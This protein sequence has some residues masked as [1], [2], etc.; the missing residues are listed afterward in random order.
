MEFL[1]VQHH[2]YRLAKQQINLREWLDASYNELRQAEAKVLQI[3]RREM[4]PAGR[5][6]FT[7]DIQRLGAKLQTAAEFAD[8]HHPFDPDA[9]WYHEFLEMVERA[10]DLLCCIQENLR[11]INENARTPVQVKRVAPSPPCSPECGKL[12]RVKWLPLESAV[13][14]GQEPIAGECECTFKTRPVPKP[15]PAPKPWWRA[16]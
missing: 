1:S 15:K 11:V 12:A 8:R 4:T 10:T 14:V 5:A 6:Y 3:H 7:Q 16:W 13:L 9:E 2:T